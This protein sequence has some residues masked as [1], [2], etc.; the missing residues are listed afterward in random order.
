MQVN[1]WI[2]HVTKTSP[3]QEQAFQAIAT[4]LSE[5]VQ[6]AMARDGKLPIMSGQKF[7]DEFGRNNPALQSK[8]LQSVFKSQPALAFPPT[9]FA[10]YAQS[11]M[12]D[13]INPVIKGD[14]DINT[15]LREAEEKINK[16]IDENKSK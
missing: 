1:E 5:D 8:R 2:L 9:Q 16:Y 7:I 6:L 10:P 14:K 3:H 4:V 12:Q 15:V 11:I 13:A